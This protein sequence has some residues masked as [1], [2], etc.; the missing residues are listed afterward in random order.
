MHF[1]FLVLTTYKQK[2]EK[3]KGSLETDVKKGSRNPPI[4]RNV[5]M[6]IMIIRVER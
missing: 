4:F 1:L 3:K 2:K 6:I 5:A